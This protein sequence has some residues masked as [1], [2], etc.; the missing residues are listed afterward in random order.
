MI[1]LGFPLNKLIR[2]TSM[3]SKSEKVPPKPVNQEQVVVVGENGGERKEKIKEVEQWLK[4]SLCEHSLTPLISPP[5][6]FKHQK[7]A[8]NE[9]SSNNNN[10][11]QT[12]VK[13]STSLN[14]GSKSASVMIPPLPQVQRR[15]VQQPKGKMPLKG[16]MPRPTSFHCDDSRLKTK[17]A[18]ERMITYTDYQNLETTMMMQ[19]EMV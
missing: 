1:K 2:S 7:Q 11:N 12:N 3:G 8:D 13:H 5:S 9:K 19:Q 18:S 10:S 6:K 15:V 14:F 16:T 4:S 17:S